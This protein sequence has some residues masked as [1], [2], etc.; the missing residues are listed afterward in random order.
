MVKSRHVVAQAT[1]HKTREQLLAENASYCSLKPVVGPLSKLVKTPTYGL[2][3]P[4]K[5]EK[6]NLPASSNDDLQV[7][8]DTQETTI[9]PSSDLPQT[10]LMSG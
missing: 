4:A 9:L 3:S 10:M 7:I 2:A 8:E 1:R 5:G 6:S